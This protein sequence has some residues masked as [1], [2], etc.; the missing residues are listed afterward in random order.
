MLTNTPFLPQGFLRWAPVRDPGRANVHS[1]APEENHGSVRRYGAKRLRRADRWEVHPRLRG[2]RSH[3]TSLV[4]AHRCSLRSLCL[5]PRGQAAGGG[6]RT[7]RSRE[8]A[9]PNLKPEA[10]S[11]GTVS[12]MYLYTRHSCY[13]QKTTISLKMRRAKAGLK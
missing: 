12:S 1:W 3:P 6:P 5:T 7:A 9:D 11:G 8:A 2:S 10:F 4:V 13:S